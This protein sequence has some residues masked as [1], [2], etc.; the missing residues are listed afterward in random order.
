MLQ[1]LFDSA[2][3]E[4]LLL[5][6]LANDGSYPSEIA[7]NFSFNLNAVQFQ[8]KKLEKAGVL[9]SQL[10]GKVRLY[11]LNPAYPF[12]MELAALLRKRFTFLS[13]V[14]RDKYYAIRPQ[15]RQAASSYEKFVS[16]VRAEAD[17]YPQQPVRPG[18]G[19][20]AVKKRKQSKKIQYLP[21]RIEPLDFSID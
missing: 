9:Y 2:V 6:L 21:R 17:E 20:K 3:K 11:G 18:T 1:A 15:M 16:G 7:R 12:A 14:D 10:R 19:E 8:L 4:K 5:Y 13:A